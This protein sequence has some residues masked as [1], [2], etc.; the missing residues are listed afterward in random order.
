LRQ[1]AR[2]QG[3]KPIDSIELIGTAEALPFH[4]TI[5]AGFFIKLNRAGAA[6]APASFLFAVMMLV[7]T[8]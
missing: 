8:G 3:L 5:L 4:K 1:T 6:L 2:A 7:E